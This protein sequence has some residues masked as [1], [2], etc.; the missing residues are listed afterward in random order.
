[1]FTTS[2]GKLNGTPPLI[3][4][5]HLPGHMSKSSKS[6]NN[7][8][9]ITATRKRPTTTT[10]STH[11]MTRARGALRTTSKGTGTTSGVTTNRAK[12]TS[13]ISIGLE[14]IESSRNIRDVKRSQ[15]KKKRRHTLKIRRLGR[16]NLT[17]STMKNTRKG[18]ILN[19][20]VTKTLNITM[21]IVILTSS[22]NPALSRNLNQ[23]LTKNMNPS[24]I[25]SSII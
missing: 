24:K 4:Q 14:R 21:P 13:R 19:L 3:T 12:R 20:Q 7:P 17:R 25:V 10:D 6:K 11:S 9:I 23:K 8:A 2:C 18:I 15:N 16:I 5:V 22:K 1:M